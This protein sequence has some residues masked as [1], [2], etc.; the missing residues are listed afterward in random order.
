M[1]GSVVDERSLADDVSGLAVGTDPSVENRSRRL[2][3]AS[4]V[5][6]RFEDVTDLDWYI[7]NVVVPSDIDRTK[8]GPVRA[9][10]GSWTA[11]AHNLATPADQSVVEDAIQVALRQG[12][13]LRRKQLR[14]LGIDEAAVRRLLRRRKWTQPGHGC[15]S[16]IPTS[17]LAGDDANVATRKA[18]TLKAVS[19]TLRRRDHAIATASAA[20]V[21]GLPVLNVP[22]KPELVAFADVTSGKLNAAHVR[23]ASGERGF[24]S[25]FGV[26]LTG[27]ASTVVDLARFDARSGLMAAD[28]ALHEDLIGERDL[29]RVIDAAAGRYG[30]QRAREVLAMASPLIESPLESLTHLALHDD[31]FPAPVLQQPIRCPNGSTYWVDFL[32]PEL[33][34]ILEADGRAKYDGD[35][36][37]AEKKREIALT[38]AG[39]RIV[40]VTWH[41]VMRDWPT[42]SAWLRDLMARTP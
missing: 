8:L 11:L 7:D 14:A 25:W 12:F 4:M 1:E 30:I 3:P 27:V 34:L 21:H 36:L 19:A 10:Q 24:E 2:A 13:V 40:R 29:A 42:T 33:R 15:V 31:G 20:I 41:D 23:L 38:R 17:W 5:A 35:A 28:A 39:Y 6:M 37:W 32:W 26:R 22:P 18:H 9:W 16:V